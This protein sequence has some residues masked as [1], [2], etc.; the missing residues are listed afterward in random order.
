MIIKSLLASVRLSVCVCAFPL[1]TLPS[2]AL[3]LSHPTL[4]Q[5][6]QQEHK[7]FNTIMAQA[8]QRVVGSSSRATTMST[9]STV[10]N[11]NNERSNPKTV[12][13]IRHA[14]SLE[15]VA[16]K[17]ARRVQAA[18]V[19]R[20]LPEFTDVANAFQLTFKMFRPSVVNA[21]LSDFGRAQV[22]QLHQN[23][24]KD[25][26]WQKQSQRNTC[27]VVHSPLMRA[28]QTAYG[29]LWGPEHMDDD[30]PPQPDKILDL[31]FLKEVNP[32]EI[33]KD[34]FTPWATQKTID[35]R[36]QELE[37]WLASRPED[38][39]VLVGHSVY[40]KRMLNLPQTF[41]NCDVWKATF[42]T[43][44]KNG[45]SG[46]QKQNLPRSWVSLQRLYGFKP[47]QL[48]VVDEEVE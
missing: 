13:L 40:F 29:S 23:L 3:V 26:F 9:T 37:E 43:R 2:Q 45:E 30:V 7:S 46:D 4:Q 19:N 18:Y 47:D 20:K 33:I 42:D 5:Q 25:G 15:N 16:Y 32:A 48:P 34:A 35:Y 22:S 38:T 44:E 21:A 28:K 14:E 39:I 27:L 8:Q 6:E 17:G 24:E 36:I 1:A 11:R 10:T 12:Y 41:D 31:P